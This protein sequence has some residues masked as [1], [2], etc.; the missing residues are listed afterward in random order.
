V[1]YVNAACFDPAHCSG[2][3]HQW[4]E[5]LK[6]CLYA[7]TVFYNPALM[8]TKMAILVLYYRM[9]TAHRFLRYASLVT[10]VVVI[11]AGIVLTFLNICQCHPISAGYS[12]FDGTCIDIVALY[13]SSA[14]INVLTDLAILLLPLPI[15][16]SLRLEFWQKII[17]VATFMVGSFVTIVDVVRIVYLQEALK[18][19]L[20][21]NPLASIT[22]TTRPPDFTFHISFSL[23]W[24]AVEV[25]VGIICCCVLVLKPLVMRVMPNLRHPHHSGRCPSGMSESLSQFNISMGPRPRGPV[26]IGVFIS[27]ISDR[28][29]ANQVLPPIS[30]RASDTG[31]MES[32]SSPRPPTVSSMP[33]QPAN[34]GREDGEMDFFEM[35][36]S[37]PPQL[38]PPSRQP[39]VVETQT[40]RKW[41]DRRSAVH[42]RRDT[43]ITG[44]SQAPTQSFFDFVSM[45]GK[46]PLTQLS[47]REAWWPILFGTSNLE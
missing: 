19:E 46:V 18:V 22:A 7:F 28:S 21:V 33:E 16:T 2:I 31:R 6:R 17:L 23:M 5:P 8:T 45:K 13:L 39:H 43:I 15:L 11:V 27:P 24:S 3:S 29:M 41:S 14:P 30:P 40:R 38:A 25:S 47:A 12:D 32:L 34:E 37:D 20:E 9:A 4:D 35:L 26:H 42:S 44:T 36:A 10:M 1:G